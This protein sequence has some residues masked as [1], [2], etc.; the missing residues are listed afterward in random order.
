MRPGVSHQLRTP[1]TAIK[2][3]S[4]LLRMTA[5]GQLDEEQLQ[6][7]NAIEENV[8]DLLTVIQQTLDLFHIE[9]GT[10][11]IDRELI[12]LAELI[13]VETQQWR[14]KMANK[15]LRF[16]T[17]PPAEAVWIEGDWKRLTWVVRNLLSN[18][19]AYTPPGGKV[20][21]SLKQQ[22]GYAQV[23]VKDTGVGVGKDDQS[24]LFD[25]FFRGY[26]REITGDVFGTGLGLYV[27]K[28]I[29]EA[30]DRGKIWVD[31]EL[32]RGSTFSFSLPVLA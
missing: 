10:L 29:I 21:L 17:S 28:A 32:N 15:K 13:Q 2:G 19:H 4:E 24:F 20:Q 6:Y 16:I 5:S 26:P 8:S 31:S 23:D 14:N 1:L 7:V 25:R 9:A 30:H 27:S 22:Q 18:A 3:Y 12:N 11:G